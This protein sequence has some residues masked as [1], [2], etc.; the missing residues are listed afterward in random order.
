MGNAYMHIPHTIGYIMTGYYD[1]VLVLIPV[2][3]LGIT[4]ALVVV[5]LSV[6]AAVPAGS[7]VAMVLIGHAMFVNAPA[8]TPDEPQSAR[9]PL[10][11]D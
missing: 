3:L 9:P 5:G 6:T 10:N 4:A 8:D 2:A 11:A 7:L 1:L